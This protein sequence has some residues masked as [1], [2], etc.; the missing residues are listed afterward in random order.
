MFSKNNH[1]LC[2]VLTDSK[3]YMLKCVI[4]ALLALLSLT[5][6]HAQEENERKKAKLVFDIESFNFFDNREVHS[7]YQQSQTLFGT[8]LGAEIG[9][10]FRGNSIMAGVNGLIDFGSKGLAQKGL[11]LYYHYENEHFSGA[12][13]SFPRERLKAELPDIFLYDST[14]YY[15]PNITGALIAYT[16][17]YGYAEA[18]CNWLN[19]QG[20]GEREIFEIVSDGRF[21][22]KGFF[23]GW[24]IQLLHFSVPRPADG[25]RVYDKLMLNPHVGIDRGFGWLDHLGVQ[26]GLM[27][28]LNRDRNDMK[29]KVPVGF[30]GDVTLRKWRVELRNRIYVGNRQFSDYEKYGAKLHRGDPYYR[31]GLYNR[32]DVSFYLL[33]KPFVQCYVTASFHY[34]EKCLDNSQLVILRFSPDSD[35]FR[36]MFRR[37]KN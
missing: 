10:R 20:P 29:W 2:L 16:C 31:S 23:G 5:S 12:F 21:G 22:Y 26:A 3:S 7:P 34:T 25:S 17:K 27:L 28:S 9:V 8:R 33:N 4:F 18:Y 36:N 30:L 35:I 24:N 1:Y 15:S 19:K 37:K 32:T 14:R 13:G 6:V 11:T